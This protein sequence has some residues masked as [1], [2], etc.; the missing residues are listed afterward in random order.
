MHR[1]HA[2]VPAGLQRIG[3]RQQDLHKGAAAGDDVVGAQQ[4]RA[5][6]AI[7]VEQVQFPQRPVLPQRPPRQAAMPCTPAT[8]GSPARPHPPAEPGAADS[9]QPCGY[10]APGTRQGPAAVV[11]HIST[12]LLIHIYSGA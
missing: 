6:I 12:A 4:Q 10:S 5:A 1:P 2:R 3:Q 7:A 9:G 8:I 11:I